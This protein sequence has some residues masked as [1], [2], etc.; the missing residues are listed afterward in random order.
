VDFVLYDPWLLCVHM[1]HSG[2]QWVTETARLFA[3]SKSVIWPDLG[4][5]SRKRGG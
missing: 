5:L 3:G 4:K 2:S 1:S